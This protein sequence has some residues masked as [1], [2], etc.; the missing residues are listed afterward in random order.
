MSDISVAGGHIAVSAEHLTKKF[1]DFT[2]VNDVVFEVQ[3]GEV[4]GYLGPNGSGKTTTMRMLLGLLSPTS[5]TAHV[6]GYDIRHEGT[7]ILPLIGY[8]SQKF[9]LYDELTVLENMD[10][11]AGIYDLGGARRRAAS[12]RG[13]AAS[14]AARLPPRPRRPDLNRLAPATGARHRSR[15]RPAPAPSR[16]AYQWRRPLGA[17]PVLGPDRPAR[18]QRHHRLCHNALYG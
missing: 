13:F 14:R 12:G 4:V 17:S 2:A 3:T 6:L 18:D 8:M 10:F 1:G 15:A 16:R 5:G 9:A 7:A 11:Y